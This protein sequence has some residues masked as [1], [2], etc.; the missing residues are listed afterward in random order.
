MSV[1]PPF[2]GNR[3]EETIAWFERA[4]IKIENKLR[5][6]RLMA[7][8]FWPTKDWNDLTDAQ[9]EMITHY[10]NVVMYETT[11][12]LRVEHNHDENKFI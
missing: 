6:A 7:E 1:I 4:E 5:L 2:K 11:E 9:Y 10:V 8:R 12:S 3:E